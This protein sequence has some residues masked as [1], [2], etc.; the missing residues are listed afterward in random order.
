MSNPRRTPRTRQQII[1]ETTAKLRAQATEKLQAL[2]LHLHVPTPPSLASSLLRSRGPL[3]KHDELPPHLQRALERATA[4]VDGALASERK[5][6]K[7]L[8]ADLLR[9]EAF[10][11]LRQASRAMHR[12]RS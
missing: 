6:V 2:L 4:A 12:G 3:F 10:L 5:R 11:Q 1:D 7:P 8:R 9:M